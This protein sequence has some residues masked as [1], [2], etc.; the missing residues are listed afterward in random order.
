MKKK[1]LI[2]FS[3]LIINS[4]VFALS[5][6]GFLG[7]NFNNTQNEICK[8]M[9]DSGWSMT[10]QSPDKCTFKKDNTKYENL[11]IDD[12]SVVFENNKCKTI[13]VSFKED[14][15]ENA[16]T[17]AKDFTDIVEYFIFFYDLLTVNVSEKDI[18]GK[19]YLIRAYATSDLSLM[20]GMSF[21]YDGTSTSGSIY[22]RTK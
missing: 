14:S 8:T 15:S 12:I 20:F 16:R 3:L 6:R 4:S 21:G 1:L 13:F 7:I 17:Y 10:Y 18:G 9:A 22:F 2:I 19:S 11:Y 5:F